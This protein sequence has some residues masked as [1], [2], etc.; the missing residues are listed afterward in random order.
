MDVLASYAPSRYAWDIPAWMP[1][2]LDPRH[3]STTREKV[4]LG[5]RL[6]YDSRLSVNRSR[7]CATCHRQELAFTDGLAR[8][9]GVRRA[10]PAQFDVAGKPRLCAGADVGQ[11]SAAQ[12]GAAGPRP[13]A[14]TATGRTRHGRA[15]WAGRKR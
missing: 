7:S 6:F 3:N 4:E 12:P 15:R 9:P 11:S 13:A 14:W 10:H 5:R 1:K 8:S 2:P